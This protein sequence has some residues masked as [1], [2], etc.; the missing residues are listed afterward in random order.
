MKKENEMETKTIWGHIEITRRR[1]SRQP[2]PPVCIFVGPQ[3]CH[4]ITMGFSFWGVGFTKI[5]WFNL[6]SILEGMSD[7]C[8]QT[9]RE[10]M[11]LLRDGT[12]GENSLGAKYAATRC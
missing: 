8:Q 11:G 6:R 10:S 9:Q 5:L 12:S 3:Y 7:F 2:W 1:A 4:M